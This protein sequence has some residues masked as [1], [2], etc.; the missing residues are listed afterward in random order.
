MRPLISV[1]FPEPL[2]L[3]PTTDN[4]AIVL[5]AVPVVARFWTG[6][7]VELAT[8]PAGFVFDGVSRPAC[9]A[10]W[11]KRWGPAV[12]EALLHDY[13]LELLADGRLAKPKFLL[14]LFF[15][16]ALVCGGHSFIR[17]T[18][19]FL[20]VRTRPIRRRKASAAAA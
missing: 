14:D 9:F 1:E 20:A 8:I 5:E 11:V 12:E 19:M 6:A 4:R 17:S 16:L 7:E 18:L 3:W 10:W 2:M 13:F 15:L